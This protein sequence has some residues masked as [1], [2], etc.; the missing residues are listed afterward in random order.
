MESNI[1]SGYITGY[2]STH[3]IIAG[4]FQPG[5]HGPSL[6][7]KRDETDPGGP[8]YKVKSEYFFYSRS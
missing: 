2:F 1:S 3:S 6:G 4:G 5:M 7:M 8:S